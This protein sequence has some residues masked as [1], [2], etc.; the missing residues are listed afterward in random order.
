M[1]PVFFVLFNNYQ[2]QLIIRA[3]NTF[4]KSTNQLNKSKLISI[5]QI[6]LNS[7]SAKSISNPFSPSTT[8]AK[9]SIIL[10]SIIMD[11]IVAV[12]I[13]IVS[14]TIIVVVICWMGIGFPVSLIIPLCTFLSLHRLY[15]GRVLS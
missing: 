10:P 2:V 7:F 6:D 11:I 13:V 9:G 12:F 4:W 14:I 5:Y 15:Q 1:V 8:R 3:E